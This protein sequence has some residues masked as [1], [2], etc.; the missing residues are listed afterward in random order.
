MFLRS[1]EINNFRCFGSKQTIEFHKGLNVLVGEN[2]SGKSAVLD[3]IRIV[4]GTTD[5]GWYKIELSDFYNEN[6]N[7]EIKIVCKFSDLSEDEKSAF[8]ECLSYDVTK[9]KDGSEITVFNLYLHWTCKYLT[10]FKTPRVITNI[11]TGINGD[12]PTPSQES[13][14]LL[15]ATYLRP[16]RDAYSNMQ[17]GRGSRLSQ[18]LNS[19][20]DLKQGKNLAGVFYQPKL[21]IVSCG[22]C[23]SFK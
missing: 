20:S 2:D 8:L 22:Y 9:D 23:K 7:T 3:A 4:L 14:E 13:R 12:G 21:V 17:S 11:S 10:S 18:I 6:Q 1:I 19:V 15:K 16:L 5:Q